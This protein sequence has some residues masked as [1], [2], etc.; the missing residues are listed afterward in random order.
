[1]NPFYRLYPLL[2]I[3]FLHTLLSAQNT[4]ADQLKVQ[5]DQAQ[6][7]ERVDLLLKYST[8][9]PS[10]DT[11]ELRIKQA[12]QH[13]EKLQY[14]EGL[15]KAYVHFCSLYANKGNLQKSR[16]YYDSAMLIATT[17]QL[18]DLEREALREF[19]LQSA[20][21]GNLS[22][23]L[24]F[25]YQANR[26]G[27]SLQH[28][29]YPAQGL[30]D[31]AQLYSIRRHFDYI[32]PLLDSAYNLLQ[33]QLEQPAPTGIEALK[34]LRCQVLHNHVGS[35]ITQGTWQSRMKALALY[36]KVDSLDC[37]QICS[38]GTVANL[39]RLRGS[40][41]IDL[42]S[43][44]K[45]FDYLQQ[46]IRIYEQGSSIEG[47]AL[48]YNSLA[49]YYGKKD[50]YAKANN[51][52]EK[53]VGLAN[54]DKENKRLQSHI[55]KSKSFHHYFQGDTKVAF[56][57]LLQ[58]TKVERE[59]IN[60]QQANTLASI[61]VKYETADKERQIAEQ[62]LE[63][64]L[65]QNRFNQLALTALALFTL[66][67]GLFLWFQNRLKN[68]TREARR[69]QEVDELKTRLFT[70]I[71]H[72]FRTPLTLL[73][74]ALS[75]TN[76][77]RDG[78][79]ELSPQQADML[80]RN[81]KGLQS[82]IDQMLDLSKLEAGKMK[83][84]ATQG[85]LDDFVRNTMLAYFDVADQKGIQLDLE[86]HRQVPSLYFDPHQ[87]DKIISNLLSNAIK[88]TGENGRI[89]VI[90]DQDKQHAIVRVRDTGSGIPAE[91]LTHIFDRFYQPTNTQHQGTGIGLALVKELVELH[92]GNIKVE[93]SVGKGSLFTLYLPV[94]RDHLNEDEILVKTKDTTAVFPSITTTNRGRFLLGDQKQPA[95][96][97]KDAPI[98]LIAEDNTDLCQQLSDHLSAQYQVITAADGQA[99]IDKALLHIP[100]LIL[101]DAMMPKKNGFEV[102]QFLKSDNR[103]DH[104]PVIMLTAKATQE[105]KLRG[106][107]E[108]A[109]AYLY[110]PFD[111][112]ELNLRIEHL[113]FQRRMLREKYLQSNGN[114]NDQQEAVL[115]TKDQRFLKELTS[116]IH[117]HLDD[118]QFTIEAFAQAAHMSR[119]QL[120]RKL[121]ALT[122]LTPTLF[123][124][125]IRLQQ[126]KAL[127]ERG[128]GNISEV[129]Y[130]V[131][132]K[133]AGYF[134]KC[135]KQA[136]GK[137]PS[138]FR[139]TNPTSLKS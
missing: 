39:T 122:D 66:A 116:I 98:I 9:H 51:A 109:D 12:K 84:Q 26:I 38:P 59:M 114:G 93:S 103:T 2:A 17:Y 15:G 113:I 76:R 97:P 21:S 81:A 118:D 108:G 138:E 79:L 134:A 49:V 37:L 78:R 139:T 1:M 31:L 8:T 45:G 29:L 32:E 124:R 128:Y 65:S 83:L 135:F 71:S 125:K 55:I 58:A 80:L 27:D 126:G 10:L 44:E 50:D 115:P 68:N 95:T 64:S 23:A 132:F 24:H 111:I 91:E 7:S 107:A 129:A 121:K 43:L 16:L 70:N 136:Y 40:L 18:K 123:L 73:M 56:E 22:D 130:A 5:L 54:Q 99:G 117:D 36:K 34:E 33:I 19:Q 101:L 112:N 131:G 137:L 74:N 104:I 85:D 60:E 94:G 53:A 133:D 72:E 28:P 30:L 57:N 120:H 47:H 46:A 6:G 90:I 82:L 14:Q 3:L 106:L 110:K 35:Q 13:A 48:A 63:L 92:R 89:S 119:S 4:Q 41:Y 67:L 75:P 20:T 77:D 42:D 52:M 62:K 102:C 69:L 87:L 11:A 105:D 86:I 127:L 100:D 88:F 61:Q 25:I 96:A